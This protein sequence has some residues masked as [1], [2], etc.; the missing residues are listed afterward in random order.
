MADH[1]AFKPNLAAFGVAQT[2][3]G[4]IYIIK[5]HHLYKI[6]RSKNSSARLKAAKTWLPDMMLV[7]CKPFWE[8]SEKER[9]LHVGFS[10]SW[11]CGEWFKF[12][13]ANDESILLEGF[14]EFSDTNRDVNS[15]DFYY[16]FNG[17]GMTDFIAE[18]N[19]RKLSIKRFL[20]QESHAKKHEH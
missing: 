12:E 17:C 3:P 14:K 10:R 9:C 7:G 1:Y 8:T 4:F 16:W 11:Y 20:R 15:V 19:H 2:D 5:H 6:G 13:D 18:Q